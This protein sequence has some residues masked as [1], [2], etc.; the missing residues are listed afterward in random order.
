MVSVA[1][2]AHPVVPMGLDDLHD[3]NFPSRLT[4]TGAGATGAQ[5]GSVVR[6]LLKEGKYAI[7]A[8]TR[9]PPRPRLWFDLF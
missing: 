1:V 9:D 7:R 3:A 4:L 2:H 6:A 8:V 5:G